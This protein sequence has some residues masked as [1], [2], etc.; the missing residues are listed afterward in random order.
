MRWPH[1]TVGYWCNRQLGLVRRRQLVG[2]LPEATVDSWVRRGRLEVVQRGVL[3]PAGAAEVDGQVALAAVL[4]AGTGAV[5]AGEHLLAAYGVE[6]AA[7]SG[8]PQVLV[9]TSR[10]VAHV[11]FDVRRFDV[12]PGQRCRVLGCLPAVRIE[13]AALLACGSLA[14]GE[15]E[16][17]VD[18]CRWT[19]H[20]RLDRLLELARELPQLAASA[21]I[22]RLDGA[23]RFVFESPGE[24]RFDVALGT[25]G[26]LFRWQAADVVD[27]I[28]FDAYCDLART[29]LEYDGRVE[30]RD[31]SRDAN[32]DLRANALGIL[33]L[34]ITKNMLRPGRIDATVQGIAAVVAERIRT[35]PWE[36]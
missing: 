10:H 11:D 29:A 6:G 15:V 13:L 31:T 1:P 25:L 28:R 4:R 14:D 26:L 7:C 30:E 22:L 32:K 36:R 8:A 5:L 12:P 21:C 18:R 2:E 34:H 17:L 19:N 3:R 33:V 35:R 16:A 24:R 9:P 23:G 27:G 20:L